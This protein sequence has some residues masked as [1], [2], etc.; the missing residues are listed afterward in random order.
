MTPGWFQVT[1]KL[2]LWQDDQFL[3]LKDAQSKLGDLPG[4]RIGQDE[5]YDFHGALQR[6]LREEL[7]NDIQTSI[8]P[9]PVHVFPHFVVKDNAPAIAVLF[10]GTLQSGTPALSN[11][12]SEMRWM[13]PDDD[14]MLL[15]SGTMLDGLRKYLEHRN[16][17]QP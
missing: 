1:L 11:E 14:L 16:G 5:L 13:S 9:E 17:V 10:E 6:E 4:G 7:G 3:A 8:S 15:F 2:I 12:H